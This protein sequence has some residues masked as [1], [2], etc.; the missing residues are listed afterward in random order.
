M[1][2]NYIVNNIVHTLS[3]G[4]QEYELL[5]E[6]YQPYSQM[7]KQARLVG[8]NRGGSSTISKLQNYPIIE[9]WGEVLS[10][11]GENPRKFL[12]FP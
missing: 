7:V 11:P 1:T 12:V 5:I 3:E 9:W 10:L 8:H 6:I 2:Y 4:A